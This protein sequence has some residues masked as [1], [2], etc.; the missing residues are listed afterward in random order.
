METVCAED[1]DDRE[2]T[3]TPDSAVLLSTWGG[4]AHSLVEVCFAPEE[5][6]MKCT[7]RLAVLLALSR[8]QKFRVISCL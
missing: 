4:I 5:G 2:L 6:D 3:G 8:F 1:A 7:T